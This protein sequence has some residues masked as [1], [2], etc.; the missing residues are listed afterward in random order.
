MQS[1]RSSSSRFSAASLRGLI[2]H[3]TAPA[4][5][6][7]NTHVNA[8]GSL[9]ERIATLSPGATPHADQRRRDAEAELPHL[10]VRRA[11]AV[12][13]QAGSPGIDRGPLVEVV[14]QSHG[15][16]AWTV[17]TGSDTSPNERSTP[18]SS[19]CPNA[20]QPEANPTRLGGCISSE[21][22]A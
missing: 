2:G 7:P 20:W 22:A 10:G 6:I 11:A 9:A 3:H 18:S 16:Q 5:L 4:R 17:R 12:R 1:K 13:G 21:Y 15:A 14:D 8:T 19:R